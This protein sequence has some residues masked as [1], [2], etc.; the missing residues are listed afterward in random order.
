MFNNISWQSYWITIA[1]FTA[2]YYLTIYLLYFRK[3]FSI[4]WRRGSRLKED[5]PFSSDERAVSPVL[6][7][8]QS[9]LVQDS[10]DFQLPGKDT[11]EQVVYTCMDEIAA[12]LEQAKRNKCEKA[13]SLPALASILRKYPVLATSEYKQSITTVMIHQCESCCSV[14]LSAEE[15][16]KVRVER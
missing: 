2:G 9:H 6:T 5:E 3:D 4:P 15:V 12:Y 1:L 13:E 7:T 16:A 10:S 8:E 11:L 14:H